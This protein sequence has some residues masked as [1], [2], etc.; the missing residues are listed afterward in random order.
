MT[1][2]PRGRLTCA[3]GRSASAMR[4]RFQKSS[5][6]QR[7]F[8]VRNDLPLIERKT[9]R[10]ENL[11]SL[12][13]L[14]R[15]D[16]EVVSIRR[17]QSFLDCGPPVGDALMLAAHSLLDLVDNRV[18]IFRARVVARHDRNISKTLGDFTHGG[19]LPSVAL[20]PATEDDD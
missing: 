15:E 1:C 5:A 8:D 14:A 4:S 20:A 13:P 2:R 16:N 6:I 9:V 7:L 3:S 10:S 12:L 18:R 11:I 19:S 17:A